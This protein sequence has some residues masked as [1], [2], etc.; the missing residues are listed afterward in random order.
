MKNKQD[1]KTVS[2]EMSAKLL[3]EGKW[4]R[5]KEDAPLSEMLSCFD[6]VLRKKAIENYADY[7]KNNKGYEEYFGRM[8]RSDFF[9]DNVLRDSAGLILALFMADEMP[10]IFQHKW[11]FSEKDMNQIMQV[12][13]R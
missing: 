10:N 13:G 5:D 6:E 11:P 8:I 7:L 2:Q 4:S 1:W 3:Y 9:A 12:M